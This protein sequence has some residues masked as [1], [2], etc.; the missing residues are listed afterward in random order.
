MLFDY[1]HLRAVHFVFEVL[2]VM[3]PREMQEALFLRCVLPAT[4]VLKEV[5]FRAQKRYTLP[6]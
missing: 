6:N 3:A 5:L 1:G 2:R 4:T